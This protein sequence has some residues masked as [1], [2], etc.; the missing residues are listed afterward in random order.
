MESMLVFG[1]S[2][3][4]SLL[5]AAKE[6]LDRVQD[7]AL[8]QQYWMRSFQDAELF[9]DSFTRELRGSERYPD[10][11]E[12]LFRLASEVADPVEFGEWLGVAL[13]VISGWLV[14]RIIREHTRGRQRRGCG[15]AV[16][17]VG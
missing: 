10:A 3:G 4:A 16:S 8:V 2:V 6:L 17:R 1:A 13:M 14:F 7:D 15:R 9:R 5:A 11:Y 12:M